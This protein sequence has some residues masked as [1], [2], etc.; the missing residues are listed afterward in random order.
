MSD[1][2]FPISEKEASM[3]HDPPPAAPPHLERIRELAA[4]LFVGRA[5]GYDVAAEFPAQVRRGD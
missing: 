1:S 5:D 4:E 3:L 2:H